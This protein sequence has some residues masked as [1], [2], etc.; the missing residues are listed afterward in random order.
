MAEKNGEIFER[1]EKKYFLSELQY[2][3]LMRLMES[4]MEID[5]Y[6][7]STICNIYYDTPDFELIRTSIGKPVYKEKLRLRSYGIPDDM[8]KVFIEIK[9]KYD[10]VVY[11]RRIQLPYKEAGKYLDHGIRPE[12]MVNK[13]ILKELDYFKGFYNVKPVV[14]I[15]YD[16]IAVHG[17]EDTSLR[18]TFDQNIRFR[19]EDLDL[20][21]GDAGKLL[22]HHNEILMEVKAPGA[23][24]L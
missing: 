17:K 8:D 9:K 5:E 12:S 4:H 10:G 21:L 11:K 24:P 15:A 14:Y 19:Q 6:G 3:V 1:I 23:Y 22:F 16:R 13:Q 2:G 18:I 20:A 7:K